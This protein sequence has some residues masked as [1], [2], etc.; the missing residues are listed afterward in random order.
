MQAKQARQGSAREQ[1]LHLVLKQTLEA[2]ERARDDMFFI[3]EEA[4][5]EHE[6]IAA[7]LERIRMEV[8]DQIK[9]VDTL[10]RQDRACRQTLLE[11]SRNLDQFEESRVRAA[12]DH[13]RDVQWR[14][15][16]AMDREQ[17]QRRIRDSLERRLQRV[18]RTLVRAEGMVSKLG[19][20]MGLL[21]G[22]MEELTSQVE[23]IR[24]RQA[25][26][27]SIIRAQE[28]ERRRV[29][30]DVHDGPA[31]LLANVALRLEVSERLLDSDL[32]RARSELAGLRDA[33]RQSLQDVRKIIFDLRPMAL[34][35]LGLVPALK[36]FTGAL[37]ERSGLA[38]QINVTGDDHRHSSALEIAAFR[39]VQ[40][41]LNNVLKHAGT[42]QA[43][44]DVHIDEEVIR[45]V[46]R[47]Q[48]CGFNA[49]AQEDA[50]G[51]HFGL[52]NI[53]ERV[54]L[55]QGTMAID[56]RPGAGTTVTVTLPARDERG[57]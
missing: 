3:A 35:D 57:E 56:S 6:E 9:A 21:R 46:I 37:K 8:Q 28:E 32:D 42:E 2:I 34:E 54:S 7:E 27:L 49:A 4:R 45:L 14:L 30:R 55:L 13:A 31:Q 50:G 48:G 51:D 38:C 44:V 22:N 15:Q 1:N 43:L 24:Q 26:G 5:Q 25:L 10:Q 33:V 18:R 36:T 20:A 53:R 16:T 23:G 52:M 11:L 29:A 17:N 40:E 47:D 19:M 39:I 12:Y 41:G